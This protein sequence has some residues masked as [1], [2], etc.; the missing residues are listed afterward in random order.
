MI[1]AGTDNISYCSGALPEGRN[2]AGRSPTVEQLYQ[3]RRDM[4]SRG[5]VKT[6]RETRLTTAVKTAWLAAGSFLSSPG[7]P[8]YL[9]RGTH[10]AKNGM[11]GYTEGA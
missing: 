6:D 5:A 4:S 1:G 7:L 11:I 8:G 3:K 2:R 10:R 9:A